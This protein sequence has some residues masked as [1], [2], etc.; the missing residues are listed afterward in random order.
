VLVTRPRAQAAELVQRLESAGATVSVA[1]TIRVIP[2]EDR[3]PLLRTAADPSQFDWIVFASANAVDAFID[4][5]TEVGA[6]VR[7]SDPRPKVCAVG[8]RTAERLRERGVGVALVPSE[9]RAEALVDALAASSPLSE[10]K[11]LL[12]RSEIGREVIA[13]RLR[14]AGAL[15]TDVVAY[16]TVA[17]EP[18]DNGLDVRAMLG[19]R[20]IDVVTFT[21][22]SA[23]RNFVQMHG[24]G[25]AELLGNAIIAVI[26]PVTGD[27]ARELGI[28]IHVQPSTYTVSAMVDR[29]VAYLRG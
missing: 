10:A 18:V 17:D 13:D 5:V 7:G 19:K 4:A 24:P 15:V 29:L 6:V 23:V 16:R 2:P 9:F 27:A 1:P 8:S 20:E 3:G 12:P 26:G 11:V 28:T 21:S 22:P 25:S 14:A